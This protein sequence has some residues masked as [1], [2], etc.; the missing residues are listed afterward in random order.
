MNDRACTPSSRSGLAACIR[1]H[2]VALAIVATLASC[3]PAAA[4]PP[5]I[6][7]PG[8]C[9]GPAS[10]TRLFVE[11]TRIRSGEGL[12]AITVYADDQRKF[13]K[14]HG[15]LYV[16]RVPAASPVVRACVN[17]P[18]PGTY[19]LAIYHDR[20]GNGKFDRTG[21]GLPAEDFG[22][23]NDAPTL[24]GL[25]SFS[26]VRLAVPRDGTETRVRL[27]KP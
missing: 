12:V 9:G 26:K 5:L 7:A 2:P 23:S 27:K 13:L 22:F 6:T 4:A 1:L 19:G 3:G 17:V 10:E 18:R 14:R 25:P 21:L 24:V 8:E 16:V 11:V 20:N 15:S